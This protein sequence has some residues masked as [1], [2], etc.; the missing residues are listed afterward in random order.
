MHITDSI[1]TLK[2]VGEKI[3]KNLNKVGIYT[4]E[5]LLEYYPRTYLTYNEP[6]DLSEIIP[7]KRQAIK[8][9]LH[10]GLVR[11]PGGKVEKTSGQLIDGNFKL[12]LL[13]YRMPYLKKQLITGKQ[14]VFYGV[15][16]EKKVNGSWNNRKYTNPKIIPECRNLFNPSI[17]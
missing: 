15:V 3:E 2:G 17:H 8:G 9:C 1:R 13:W 6:V 10:R 7:G 4:I 16:K 11:I 5:D 12:Q 14:Y